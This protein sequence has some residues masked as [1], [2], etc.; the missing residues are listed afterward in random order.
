MVNILPAHFDSNPGRVLWSVMSGSEKR[1]GFDLSW[2]EAPPQVI[3]RIEN[4]PIQ[5]WSKFR[6]AVVR[7]MGIDE[8]LSGAVSRIKPRFKG[9]GRIARALLKFKD[10]LIGWFKAGVRK[11]PNRRQDLGFICIPN[12]HDVPIS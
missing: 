6:L 2:V 1:R 5:P 4:F 7:M 3:R 10:G 9:H 8:F 11:G 12:L